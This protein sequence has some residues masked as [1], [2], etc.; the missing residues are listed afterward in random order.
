DWSRGMALVGEA[1]TYLLAIAMAGVGLG[2]RLKSMR[3]L[4]V[5]PFYVGLFASLVVG[6][7]SAL[8]V[9]LLGRFVHL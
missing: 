9:F 1:A 3:G 4:G 7:A 2:A 6:I 5:K 8:A